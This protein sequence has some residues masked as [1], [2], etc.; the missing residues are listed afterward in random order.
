[1]VHDRVHT[2]VSSLDANPSTAGSPKNEPRPSSMH[3]STMV[4]SSSM[5]GLWGISFS[6]TAT[7][8]FVMKYMS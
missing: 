7:D 5:L 8:P 3:E 1:M 6:S 2:I 4:C